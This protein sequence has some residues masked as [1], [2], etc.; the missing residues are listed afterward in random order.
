MK[1][2]LN[3]EDIFIVQP[4]TPEQ[5]DAVADDINKLALLLP[6]YEPDFIEGGMREFPEAFTVI[7]HNDEPV[8]Y[9]EINDSSSHDLGK[10]SMEFGGCV[11]PE[12]RDKGLTQQVA[13]QIIRQAF[14]RTGKK[15]MLALVPKDNTEARFAIA[16]LGFKY[17]GDLDGISRYKLN[18]TDALA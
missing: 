11:L 10:D 16:A 14:S 13:P 2:W 7:Y 3:P 17:F 1:N 15:K 9:I 5:V 12:Y 8:A 6:F 4:K 18:R